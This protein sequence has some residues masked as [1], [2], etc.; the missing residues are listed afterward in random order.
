MQ[1][2][3]AWLCLSL[4][5]GLL[6]TIADAAQTERLIFLS[7]QLRPIE[8]AQKMRNLILKDFSQEVDYITEPPQR[9]PMRVEAARRTGMHT[10]DV[11]GA[12]HGELQQLVPLDAL[13]PLDD[14]AGKLTT[15]GI[16]SPLLTLGKFGTAH[17]LY[18]PW[19]QASF[20]MVA[21]K[22]ALPYLPSGA[23]INALSYDQLATW[24][25]TLQQQTGKRL[26]GFPAG[27][28]GL[29]HRFFEG[30]LYPSYT[31]GVVVPFR[32]EAAEAMWTQFASLWR[33]VN[34]SSTGYN[35][36]G[37]PLLS[38][39]VWIGFDHIARLLDALR[40]KPGEFVAFPAPAGP[41]GR[42][43]MTVLAGLGVMKGTS[44]VGKA[45]ALID[46]LTQPATQ[47]V[48]ARAVGFFPVVNANLP[49]DL[50]PGLKM[51]AAA[52]ASMQSS[53]DALPV[54]PPSG[55]G[56]RDAEFDKV[57]LDT[58]QLIILRG[59]KPHAVLDREAERLNRLMTE[60]GVPCWRPDP[61]STGACQVH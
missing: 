14:L 11:V 18:I 44:D 35:F 34:P 8:E 20:V 54:L 52:I 13:V 47:I 40:E 58:F 17:Q 21:N 3:P 32:S 51:G 28:Q 2:V 37:Q 43:Y 23:D 25:S 27:P 49:P 48:T 26:L 22:R 36:M 7:T 9:F 24:A 33:S 4:G 60:A 15:R 45:M 56:P 5:V 59:Q 6:V 42:A 38:G 10:L 57:F 1:R 31:G 19:M 39:D 50:D 55:F 46:Y 30:F 16:P 53:N 29:M 61:P 12:L 41:E